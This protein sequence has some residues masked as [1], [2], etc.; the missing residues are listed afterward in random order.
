MD[1]LSKGYS[2]NIVH[3]K[4]APESSGEFPG[5][6]QN[7]PW[8]IFNT[9]KKRPEGEG[10]ETSQWRLYLEPIHGCSCVQTSILSIPQASCFFDKELFEHLLIYSSIF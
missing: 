7:F 3:I 6:Q 9:T 1:S 8:S 2:I 4:R 5:P 10:G